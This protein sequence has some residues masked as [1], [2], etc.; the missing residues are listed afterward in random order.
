MAPTSRA[1]LS[2]FRLLH[3]LIKKL[4]GGGGA[5][6]AKIKKCCGRADKQVNRADG[7]DHGL[8]S[9]ALGRGG[10]ARRRRGPLA[11]RAASETRFGGR[12]EVGDCARKC[13]EC[14]TSGLMQGPI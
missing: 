12:V 11:L 5:A 1:V 2:T 13:L 10:R 7:G 6:R 9:C 4:G 14:T 3:K 8:Y